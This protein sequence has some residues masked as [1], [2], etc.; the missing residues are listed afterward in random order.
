MSQKSPQPSPDDPSWIDQLKRGEARAFRLLIER[1]Q[2]SIYQVCLRLMGDAA[3]AEDMTQE[4]FIR[5]SQA[6]DRFRGESSLHT[7]LY[8]VA[9]NLCKNRIAYLARRAHKRHDHLPQLEEKSG[10]LWQG[11]ARPSETLA[12]PEQ[13]AEGREAQRLIEAALK[14]LPEHLRSAITLRDI[15]GL[16]YQEIVEVL[17]VPLG[18][19]KSRIHQA[20]LQLM[21]QYQALQ[22]GE[23]SERL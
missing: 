1:Y 23:G 10:D 15:E 17:N 9:I 19:V 12:T 7:W 20:R 18:T 5:A 2:G 11:R 16:T 21:K 22:D 3:E 6:I 13:V 8:R 14:A 4:T